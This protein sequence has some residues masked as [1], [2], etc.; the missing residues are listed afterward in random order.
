MD[1]YDEMREEQARHAELGY[2]P[3]HDDKEG[4]PHLINEIG[5]RLASLPVY[6]GDNSAV[7]KE[8]L[9][10]GSI[11]GALMDMA[12][13]AIK[14][15]ERFG[16]WLEITCDRRTCSVTQCS[17]EASYHIDRKPLCSEH[18]KRGMV[19]LDRQRYAS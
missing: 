4:G 9:Q 3:Q 10:I 13:R 2:T 19:E 6:A 14:W 8:L 18:F 7:R 1:K 5:Y 12:D 17:E 16:D 15:N 11:V